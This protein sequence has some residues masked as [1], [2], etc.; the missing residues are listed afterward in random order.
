MIRVEGGNQHMS[1]PFPGERKAAADAQVLLQDTSGLLGVCY[2][3]LDR[4]KDDGER[5]AAERAW[6]ALDGIVGNL[7]GVRALM[8]SLR[9]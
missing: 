6:Q 8:R 9:S 7:G 5:E 4:F 3:E 1:R 2:S